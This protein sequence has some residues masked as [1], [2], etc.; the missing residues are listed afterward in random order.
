MSFL[1]YLCI[2]FVI[3]QKKQLSLSLF[4]EIWGSFDQIEPLQF[5][6]SYEMH[7]LQ[8]TYSAIKHGTHSANIGFT[9][10]LIWL[11]VILY[12]QIF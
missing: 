1:L 6:N 10:Y 9:M 3:W 12:M 11:Y 5:Y 8:K 4:T 2:V 7:C